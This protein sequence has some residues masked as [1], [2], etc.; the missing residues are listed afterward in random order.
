MTAFGHYTTAREVVQGLD[1]TGKVALVTGGNAGIGTKTVDALAC[2][3][4]HVLLTSRSVEA[5]KRV[6]E[7][8]GKAGAKGKVS[9]MQLDLADL[10]SVHALTKELLHQR[11]RLDYIILN[12]GVMACPQG[13]T[14][15]G[16]DLQLGTNVHGHA[17]L[18]EDLL[19]HLTA[20][21]HPVR[22][23]WL[24]SEGHRIPQWSGAGVDLDDLHY[25]KGKRTYRPF[26]AYGQSKLGNILMCKEAARR[27]E[28]TNVKFYA[29]HPGTISTN[30]LRHQ[31][32]LQWGATI[33]QWVVGVNWILG[34]KTPEQGASTSVYAATAAALEDHNGAYLSDCAIVKPS[35]LAVNATLTSKFYDRVLAEINAGRPLDQ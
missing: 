31:S 1:L 28:D 4:C 9:V 18:L 32:W 22:I 33:A 25:T 7:D 24:S 29:V 21:R 16:F 2:A 8:V 34:L 5:G 23:V 27:L 15:Q 14:K 12:A 3:G 20:Q 10:A 30:L 26:P 17:A 6:A 13:K 11:Q 35:A 19:P